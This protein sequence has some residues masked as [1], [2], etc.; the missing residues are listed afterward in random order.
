MKK[1]LIS[2]LLIATT[3]IGANAYAQQDKPQ[4]STTNTNAITLEEVQKGLEEVQTMIEKGENPKE[5][6]NS[7]LEVMPSL[8]ENNIPQNG[9]DLSKVTYFLE[10]QKAN[11]DLEDFAE[12]IN[13]LEVESPI[14][15]AE[16]EELL[17]D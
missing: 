12:Y 2:T 11:Q 8:V 5:Q 16:L 4:R 10:L 9:D 7:L 17:N 13:S 1:I 6:I 15:E 14:S 3:T